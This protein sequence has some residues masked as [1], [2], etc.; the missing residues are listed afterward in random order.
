MNKWPK[1]MDEIPY[2]FWDEEELNKWL[3]MYSQ[4]ALCQ[5]LKRMIHEEES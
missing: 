4:Y 1:W 2:D 5:T 3:R